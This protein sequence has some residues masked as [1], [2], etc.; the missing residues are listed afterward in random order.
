MAVSPRAVRR[1]A[2]LQSCYIPWKGYFDIIGSVDAFVV[3]DDVQYS[4]NHWHNRNLIKTQ[5]GPKWLTIPVSKAQGAHQRIDEVTIAK[6]FAEQH[7]RT[8]V[9]AYASARNYA[10]ASALLEP[11]FQGI[12]DLSKLSDIN[13]LLLREISKALGIR[14]EFVR[15]SDLQASGARSARLLAIVQELGGATY[16]SGPSAKSYLDIGLF[17]AAGVAVE[18]M[19]YGG[20]PDYQQLHGPFEPAVS[21]VDLL[22]NEG[23]AAISAM[24]FPLRSQSAM[25][26]A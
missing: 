11:L 8:I 22:M 14:T 24:K 13:I 17:E 19:D 5:N 9:Q 12:A 1:I 23:P 2:I 26:P 16:L 6:P 10:P 7:W 18:W 21:I 20:Y 3:Y 25:T 15:S 4:K